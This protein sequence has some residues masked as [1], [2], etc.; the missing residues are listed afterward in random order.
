MGHT[1]LLD[2]LN[3]STHDGA[4]WRRS[5]TF[6]PPA[7]DGGFW[8]QAKT[9]EWGLQLPGPSCLCVLSGHGLM[10]SRSRHRHS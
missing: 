9:K 1:L 4:G 6:I 2:D 10:F 7:E 5:K 3:E 8:S